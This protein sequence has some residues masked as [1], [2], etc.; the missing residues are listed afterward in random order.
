MK[1]WLVSCVLACTLMASRT[2]VQG[3]EPTIEQTPPAKTG[4]EHKKGGDGKKEG[5]AKYRPFTGKIKEVNKTA[6]TLT[7]EGEKAQTFQVTSE[8]R[9]SK[10]SNPAT[11]DDLT[12]GESVGGRAYNNEGKWEAVKI[13]IGT[14]A[15]RG[16]KH[17]K[18]K[19]Q[20]KPAAK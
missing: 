17:K 19:E 18:E 4:A 5:R 6:K 11:F 10:E 15:V 3:A 8:T 1:T 14:L 12:V 7:L 9:I 13:N 2:P 20:S 16:G